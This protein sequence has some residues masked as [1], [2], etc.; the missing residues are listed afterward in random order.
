MT[1]ESKNYYTMDGKE[2]EK[3]K[4]ANQYYFI[5]CD[6]RSLNNIC[7]YIAKVNFGFVWIN[8]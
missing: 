5:N 1:F 6:A 7:V 4:L 8:L 3:K 2:Y